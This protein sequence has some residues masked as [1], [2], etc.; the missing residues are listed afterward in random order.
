MEQRIKQLVQA[1]IET[2]RRFFDE[3][4]PQIIQD[5]SLMVECLRNGRKIL[6][7][8]NGGSGS[9]AKHIAS[10]LVNRFAFD[11]PGLVARKTIYQLTGDMLGVRCAAT[12]TEQQYF[13][14]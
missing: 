9:D 14:A 2:T 13:S 11:R 5:V 7:F 6:W 12:V 4:A 1:N 8:G 10:E 3:G